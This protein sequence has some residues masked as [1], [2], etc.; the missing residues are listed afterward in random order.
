MKKLPSRKYLVPIPLAFLLVSALFLLIHFL[1]GDT[2]EDRRF[3]SY[4]RELFKQEITST[5]LNLHYTLADPSACGIKEYPI[6]LGQTDLSADSQTDKSAS[7]SEQADFLSSIDPS[8]LNEEN[9]LIYQLISRELETQ[10]SVQELGLLQ[11]Y[12][13]P[14]LGVQAQLPILL[15]EYTFRS[16]QDILDYMALLKEV[17]VYFSQ[18]LEFEQEKSKQGY[19]MNDAAADGVIAQCAAFIENPEEI[20]LESVFRQK[21]DSF[22]GLSA[23]E[24]SSLLQLHT[25]L[26]ASCIVPAY[27]SLIQGLTEL[28]GTGRNERGLAGL[29]SGRDYYLYLLRSQ[30]GT[31]DS[32]DII[33]QR[34]LQQ[35]L[36]DTEEMQGILAADPTLLTSDSLTTDSEASVPQ[37]PAEMLEALQQAI[38]SDF[39]ELAHTDYEIKYVDESLE[40]YLSPAFYLTPP[41]D[42]S[43]PNAIYIN[44][45]SSMSGIELFT[46]LAHEGFPGHLYQTVY[47]ARTNPQLVRYLYVPG[48]YVE[49][50]AT[51]IESYA[52][53]YADGNASLNRL[54]WLNRSVNLCLYSLM[55][56]GIHYDGWTLTDA[57]VFLH[58]FGISDTNTIAGIYQYILETPANYLKYYYGYLNFLDLRETC[59]QQA[60]DHFSLKKFHE[61]LLDLGPMPFSLLKEQLCSSF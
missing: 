48:G 60:G 50:W 9:Q 6:S 42:T 38:T 47:F 3:E 44:R 1:T 28:K 5:T 61:Q 53:S 39:P 33:R 51:Y 36:A 32:I 57:S 31:S 46:T 49:G 55:D 11:E 8:R 19:F 52:Y 29:E 17:P 54:L 58:Q 12:L 16:K 23:E 45:A 30:V 43:S 56:I 7:L 40:N 24:K 10:L 59:R 37:S 34:L 4:T 26:I 15:C 41:A 2:A 13:S 20:C 22:Q 21:L 27:Q 35:L 25:R 14:S 18:I